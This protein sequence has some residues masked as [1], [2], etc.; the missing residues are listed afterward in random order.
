MAVLCRGKDT[1]VDP[2]LDR[3]LDLFDAIPRGGA[4]AATSDEPV[5]GGS[6]KKAQE[7]PVDHRSHT[8]VLLYT[9]QCLD[10]FYACEYCP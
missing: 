7:I 3:T 6:P 9:G 4:H 8:C 2:S 10:Q 1:P 5:T